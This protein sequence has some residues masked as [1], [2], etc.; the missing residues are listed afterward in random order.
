MSYQLSP[1]RMFIHIPL[2][3]SLH[4]I[5]Y[6]QVRILLIRVIH[7]LL[8]SKQGKD[9]K[10]KVCSSRVVYK[11]RKGPKTTSTRGERKRIFPKTVRR[12]SFFFIHLL[13]F[14]SFCSQVKSNY[15]YLNIILRVLQ[16]FELFPFLILM[17]NHRHIIPIL[18][19]FTECIKTSFSLS[20]TI[21][22]RE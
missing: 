3:F 2:V 10:Q 4:G 22:L 12:D 20:Y 21:W 9:W 13:L 5:L 18:V 17:N 11:R 7:K 1:K 8:T 19:L 16:L 15:Y 6:V 14:A